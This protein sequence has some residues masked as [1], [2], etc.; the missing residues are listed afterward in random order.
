MPKNKNKRRIKVKWKAPNELIRLPNADKT[1][2]E[3][4]YDGRDILDIPHPFR[5]CILGKVGMGKS[6][7]AKNV[8]LHCQMGDTPF[9]QVYIIHGSPTTKEWNDIDPTLIM[10]D[11]PHPDELCDNEIKSLI[12]IDDFEFTKLPKESIKNLSSLF[13]FVSSHHNFSIICAYQ[14]FFD[15]KPIVRKCSN[16]FII[17]RPNNDDELGTIARRVGM[18]KESMLQIFNELLPQQRDTLMIDMT[19]G[20]PAP[21]R[22]NLFIPIKKRD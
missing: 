8:F 16:L 2:H 18:K 21:L 4:W 9:E 22:K 20:S 10:S 6:T 11:I 3:T 14:S 15:V 5:M 19:E 12:I 13:R 17:Y 1:F 7:I